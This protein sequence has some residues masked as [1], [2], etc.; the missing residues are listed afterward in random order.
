[1]NFDSKDYDR[2][3]ELA[4]ETG[5]DKPDSRLNWVMS[6]EMA[7]TRH[8]PCPI[9]D[10]P[11]TPGWVILGSEG[12]L[13]VLRYSQEQDRIWM[14][15]ADGCGRAFE[16]LGPHMPGPI[17]AQ[18]WF[19]SFSIWART[20]VLSLFEMQRQAADRKID[21]SLWRIGYSSLSPTIAWLEDWT[22][23]AECL[24]WTAAPHYY[25]MQTLEGKYYFNGRTLL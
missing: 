23:L 2:I 15:S 9:L 20:T 24:A 21:D 8:P 22:V 1:M 11:H 5:L 18:C 10:I 3:R 19:R 7:F 4:K 25:W 13:P 16:V 17:L 14:N 12:L 6:W